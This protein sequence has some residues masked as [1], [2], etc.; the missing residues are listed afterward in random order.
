MCLL[1]VNNRKVRRR[2]VPTRHGEKG[3]ESVEER[4]SRAAAEV[5]DE[6]PSCPC[7]REQRDLGF[8]VESKDAQ[9]RHLTS[10]GHHWLRFT[11]ANRHKALTMR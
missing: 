11:F 4:G 6:R 2:A 9:V 3:A 7:K 5:E 8:A 1:E 10:N